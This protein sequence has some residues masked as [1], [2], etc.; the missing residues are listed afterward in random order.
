M[1]AYHNSSEFL[2]AARRAAARTGY[3]PSKLTL[4]K[5]GVHKLTYDSPE[6]IKHFG[7]KGYGDYLWY[8][9]HDP[10]LA[11]QKRH[12][13]RTSHGEMSRIHKLG[14][15]SANELAINILW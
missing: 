1:E 13:F 9:S 8:K 5:D 4:A 14:K 2:A 3:D 10:T 6:G 12:V 7:R 15:Y 11:Q